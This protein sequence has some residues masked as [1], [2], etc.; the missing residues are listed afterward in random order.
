MLKLTNFYR[1]I[2]AGL[3]II[4]F[5]GFLTVTSFSLTA[6]GQTYYEPTSGSG[7]F[8]AVP[9]NSSANTQRKIG[10][11]II[12]PN[13][14][15]ESYL[16]L[17]TNTVDKTNPRC[18]SS[19]A[20]LGSFVHLWT[21]SCTVLSGALADCDSPDEGYVR[22]KG[23]DALNQ[24]F[25]FIAEAADMNDAVGVYA[26]DNGRSTASAGYFQ[27]RVFVAGANAQLCLNDTA[28]FDGTGTYGCISNWNQITS[29]A[30]SGNYVFLQ[31][32][33]GYATAQEGGAAISGSAVLAANTGGVVVGDPP[34]GLCPAAGP[35]CLT[36][37]DGVCSADEKGPPI[38]CSSD[39]PTSYKV[40]INKTGWGGGV[41]E[42][43]TAT[44]EPLPM[45]GTCDA[46]CETKDFWYP[47]GTSVTVKGSTNLGYTLFWWSSPLLVFGNI[48]SKTF[49]MPSKDVIIY[50]VFKPSYN[51]TVQVNDAGN[52][53]NIVKDSTSKINCGSLCNSSY[54][55]GSPVTLNATTADLTYAFTGWD[56]VTCDEGNNTGTSCSFTM[57]S[58][59]I[60]S[61]TFQ[62]L[63][64]VTMT[65][66]GGD[67][68][69]HSWA[70]C[71][72]DVKAEMFPI[73]RICDNQTTPCATGFALGTSVI[74]SPSY[75]DIWKFYSWKIKSGTAT[76]TTTDP[77]Y[78]FT[79]NG[80]TEITATFVVDPTAAGCHGTVCPWHEPVD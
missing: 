15:S 33:P 47:A 72:T 60:V 20:D 57:D 12:G 73:G 29:L 48:T 61:A 69:C 24:K 68:L 25:T 23:S 36:C 41:K 78:V 77:T 21:N 16:C 10:S 65:V 46:T 34:T 66:V 71:N 6:N 40:T 30:P 56:G 55:Q 11:L 49:T 75:R 2:A 43:G 52:V 7:G 37:G 79:V 59:Q 13:G 76:V 39:C 74:L 18:I 70:P 26:S 54:A 32:F 4:T 3:G 17:N 58:E 8:T 53:G 45:G 62:K 28:A 44:I 80:D 51:L 27:G 35:T 42:G 31:P 19:W 5:I 9:L 38:R 1:Q 50:A 67:E 64:T 22:I 14:A 63:P